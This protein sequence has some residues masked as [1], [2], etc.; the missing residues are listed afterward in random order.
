MTEPRQY[1]WSSC[2]AY[3]S[4]AADPSPA[5]IS[6]ALEWG[7]DHGSRQRRRREFLISENPTARPIDA[8]LGGG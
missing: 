4:G 2:R 8:R 3:A 6:Y 5:E 1:A 7:V